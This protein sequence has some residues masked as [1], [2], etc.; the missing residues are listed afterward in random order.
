MAFTAALVSPRERMA[1]NP[2]LPS[3]MPNTGSLAVSLSA[4]SFSVIRDRSLP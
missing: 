4:E 1:R 3:F 2:R